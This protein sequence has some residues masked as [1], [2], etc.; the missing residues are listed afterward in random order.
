[1]S[2]NRRLTALY[3][4]HPYTH[5]HP[6]LT[7]FNKGVRGPKHETLPKPKIAKFWTHF[8]IDSCL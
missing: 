4:S 1:M 2:V 6:N 5:T 3:L 8:D 7:S